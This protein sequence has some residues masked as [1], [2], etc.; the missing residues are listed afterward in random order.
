MH[1]T[2]HKRKNLH[3]LQDELARRGELVN[4]D[5]ADTKYVTTLGQALLDEGIRVKAEHKVWDYSFDLKIWNY[6][7]LI[8]VDGNYHNQYQARQRD[9]IKDRQAQ[10]RG[11][12][13]YR[14]TNEEVEKNLPGM[15]AQI[16]SS[17]NFVGLQPKEI[18]IYPLSIWEQ[19][20]RWWEKI[21]KEK[22]VDCWCEI[23]GRF[24]GR[25]DEG[26]TIGPFCQICDS[27]PRGEK[28]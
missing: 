23:C 7:I 9:Y 24:L 17:I 12:R 11:F 13:V 15:V 27:K 19:L 2:L 25:C 14:F 28:L 10:R 20:T 8:E 3:D 6:P 18:R 26:I 16:K 22:K 4:S 5:I 21:F 1:Q